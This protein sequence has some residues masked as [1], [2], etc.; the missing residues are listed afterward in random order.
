[1]NKIEKKIIAIG[2]GGFTHQLDESL[3]QFV[4]DQSKKTNNKIGFLA[5]ASN[6]DKK[7]ISL[8]YKR[9]EN[10]ESELSHFNL[11]SDVNGF[12]EWI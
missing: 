1:M 7:K 8:F 9:F 11:T 10:I 2:G 6:D 5:T 12:S 3:D 4:I